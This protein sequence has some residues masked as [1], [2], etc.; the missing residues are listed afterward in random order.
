MT[1]DDEWIDE[2]EK[3][4]TAMAEYS[5]AEYR[6]NFLSELS[7]V[8]KKQ[9]KRAELRGRIDGLS[10]AYGFTVMFEGQ[11]LKDLINE[12]MKKAHTQLGENND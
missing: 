11:E 1:K 7:L 3:L 10:A 5:D 9:L 2:I 12:D 8:L 6:A 4:N